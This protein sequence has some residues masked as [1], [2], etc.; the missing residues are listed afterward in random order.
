[1]APVVAS[2]VQLAAAAGGLPLSPMSVAHRVRLKVHCASDLGAT[3][4]QDVFPG[5]P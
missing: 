3:Q 1:M 2:Q 5:D 4:G